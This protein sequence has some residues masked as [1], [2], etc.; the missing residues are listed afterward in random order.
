MKLVHHLIR[1]NAE[2]LNLQKKI[3]EARAFRFSTV[4]FQ[5]HVVHD[6]YTTVHSSARAQRKYKF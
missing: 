2:L 1:H 3:E 5:R 4:C 6:E